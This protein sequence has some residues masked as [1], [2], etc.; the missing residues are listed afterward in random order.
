MGPLFAG[1]RAPSHAGGS[2][3]CLLGVSAEDSVRKSLW[4]ESGLR[5]PLH[6]LRWPRVITLA[7]ALAAVP[8]VLAW[9]HFQVEQDYHAL[10]MLL[11]RA[12]TQAM[13]AGPV[14]VRFTHH[15]AVV[16]NRT[17]EVLES[18]FLVT[19]AE[20]RYQTTQG[21]R[22]IMFSAGGPTSPYNVHLHGGDMMLRSWTGAERSLWVHGAGGI[23]GG[24]N[25]DWTA[26]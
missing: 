10:W 15:R 21:D 25:E 5:N 9:Q 17:G 6:S 24:R 19:L 7:L 12:R 18:L 11:H 22:R 4:K 26:N 16:E 20:V 13:M 23:T 8:T 2:G 1:I 3:R 14:T